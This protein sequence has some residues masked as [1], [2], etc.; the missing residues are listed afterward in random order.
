MY[1]KLREYIES[2]F[3]DAPDT[4][5]T[6]EL[7]EE[8][9]QNLYEKYNDLLAEG[10]SEQ[11]AFNIA[12]AGVGDVGDLIETL[13]SDGPAGSP[14]QTESARRR[15]A[16][17]VSAA[18]MLYIFE[19]GALYPSAGSLGAGAAVRIL[20]GGHRTAHLQWHDQDLLPESGRHDGRTVP[21]MEGPERQP[22]A[23]MQGD[24]GRCLGAGRGGVFSHQLFYAGMA[25]HLAFV[26]D[27]GRGDRCGQ[28]GVRPDA[29]RRR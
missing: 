15:S 22:D 14:V 9:L 19:R 28:S 6:V 2:L 27:C 5:K 21:R 3:K 11:A 26:P 24:C 23:D 4:V 7:K 20:R 16:A 17:L 1:D 12:V 13:R 25:Y 29:V 8:M 18:V 10:R